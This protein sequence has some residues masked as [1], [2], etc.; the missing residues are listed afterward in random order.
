[1]EYPTLITAWGAEDKTPDQELERVVVHEIGHQYFYGLVASNEFEEAWLD[2]GFTSY[3]EDKVMEADFG[4][5]PNL[6]VESSYIT[7][8]NAL[9]QNAWAYTGHDQYAENVY[10]RGKL[11]LKAI[12][13]QVGTKTMDRIMRTYF[14][15]W[16]FKHPSTKDFQ[17]VVEEV[18]KTKWDDFFNEYVYGSMMIDY[19]I[20][21]IHVKATGSKGTG[22]YEST[23]LI[24]KR[25]GNSPE[26]PIQFHFAD[27]TVLDKTWD[28]KESSIEYKLTHTTPVDWVRIDPNYSLIL[29]NKHINN[30]MQAEVDTKWKLRLNLGIIQFLQAIFGWVAW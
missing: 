30:F 3:A 1:M 4:A 22:P 14:Q 2:E 20:E 15:K 23:V 11:V 13:K 25:G 6:P 9:R 16:Q 29:E 24:S 27:G 7:S 8:P 21:N 12:E 26:V 10:T 5:T 18:S 17:N 19:S 28:G